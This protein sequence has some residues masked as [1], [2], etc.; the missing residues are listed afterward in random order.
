MKGPVV[1]FTMPKSSS[2]SSSIRIGSGRANSA[3]S[4]LSSAAKGQFGEDWA[5]REGLEPGAKMASVKEAGSRL[6]LLL[7]REKMSVGVA[8]CGE[9]EIGV[10]IAESSGDGAEG[11]GAEATLG[12]SR[13]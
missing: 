8:G 2:R 7:L 9:G 4:S 5:M 13:F 11:D 6:G 12:K 3:Q 1:M 10:G